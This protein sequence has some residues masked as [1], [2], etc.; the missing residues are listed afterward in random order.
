MRLMLAVHANASPSEVK[1]AYRRMIKLWHP[2]R[3]PSDSSSYSEAIYRTQ[4]INAAYRLLAQDDRSQE[5]HQGDAPAPAWKSSRWWP[6]RALMSTE[7][8]IFFWVMLVVVVLISWPI[9]LLLN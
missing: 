1:S 6:F 9:S 4:R 8:V 7:D 5:L 2:D 3:F